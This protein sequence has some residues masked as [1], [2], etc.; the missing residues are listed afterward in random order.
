MGCSQS[1]PVETGANPAVGGG[2]ISSKSAG[3]ASGP[4]PK[5]SK[6]PVHPGRTAKGTAPE[7]VEFSYSNS[8]VVVL[9]CRSH[10]VTGYGVMV[11]SPRV[12]P[13]FSPCTPSCRSLD[14]LVSLPC[15]NFQA[16]TD[17]RREKPPRR[18]AMPTT[19]TTIAGGSLPTPAGRR[20]PTTIGPRTS[21]SGAPGAAAGAARTAG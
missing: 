16:R 15:F 21:R 10:D 11:T 8:A 12:S 6:P 17:R 18:T 4:V 3:K 14:C 7:N 19:T 1:V 5:G 2:V 20:P 9:R 13:N